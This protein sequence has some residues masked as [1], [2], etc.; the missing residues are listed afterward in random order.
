MQKVL[1]IGLK[2]SKQTW[3]LLKRV[4]SEHCR[5][6]RECRHPLVRGFN[7]SLLESLLAHGGNF[8]GYYGCMV[9]HRDYPLASPCLS[10]VNIL[11]YFIVCT[12]NIQFSVYI[13]K[14]LD[15][16]LLVYSIF[17]EELCTLFR[18]VETCNIE[19]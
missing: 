4:L 12:K 5:I 8:K 19:L 10:Y 14:I 17:L 9:G 6:H 7:R 13:C 16:N 11:L 15:Y 2:M 18:T 3:V 1:N